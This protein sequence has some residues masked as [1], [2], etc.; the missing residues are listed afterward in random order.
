MRASVLPT[1]QPVRGVPAR[2][3]DQRDP[4]PQ[5]DGVRAVRTAGPARTPRSGVVAPATVI[6]Y[7]EVPPPGQ[8]T[9]TVWL[10]AWAS[11]RMVPVPV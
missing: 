10:P 9:L 7:V 8:E 6:E 2:R 4:R 3:E 5:I 1:P 11:A